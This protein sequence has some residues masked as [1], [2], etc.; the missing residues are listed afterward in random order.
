MID[1][2]KKHDIILADCE[3]EELVDLKKG[4][5]QT[6]DTDFIICSRIANASHT[7]IYNLY[8]YLV[9]FLYPII[10]FINRNKFHYIICWQQFFALFFCFFCRLFNVKNV[11][12]VVACNYTYKPKTFFK[13]FYYSFF[14][15]NSE[16]EYMSVI[17][18][19]SDNYAKK[20][21]SNFD[22]KEN[23][24][25]VVPFGLPDTFHQWS[26]SKVEYVNYSFAIGRSNRDFDF[27]VNA[28]KCLPDSELLVI[29]SDTYKPKTTL[30]S[31]IIHR[32]DIVGEAQFPYIFNC[33]AMFIPIDD[34]SI[35]SGDTVLLKAMS[36]SKP[37]V[38]TS[39]STLGEMYIDDNVNG[40]LVE[41]NIDEF[42]RRV[43]ALFM[44]SKKMLDIGVNARR[45]YEIRYSRYQMGVKLGEQ[46]KN[47]QK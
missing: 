22:I 44:D 32:T 16:C 12:I 33:K 4:L 38:V 40:L 28:W 47:K 46:I 8:R 10:F 29:A 36:Y 30:P 43:L 41:K 25:I 27:L 13:K 6:L 19:L 34:G 2:K 42:A 5:D 14:K 37:V 21:S 26:L 17:H 31:N 23:K 9:Y 24:F 39:P 45:N 7:R 18:V 35:C 20:C 15:K 3:P 1:S 11:N